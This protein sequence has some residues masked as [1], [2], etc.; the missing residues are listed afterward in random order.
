MSVALKAVVLGDLRVE[1]GRIIVVD[2][3]VDGRVVGEMHCWFVLL[4]E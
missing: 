3:G 2:P 1:S 4:F